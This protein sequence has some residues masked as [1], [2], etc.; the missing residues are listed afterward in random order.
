MKTKTFPITISDEAHKKLL[1]K[2]FERKLSGKN[3]TTIREVASD[4][5]EECLLNN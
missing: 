2:Q 3:R 5:L 1:R 4:I